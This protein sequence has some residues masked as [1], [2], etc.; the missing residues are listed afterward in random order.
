LAPSVL[1]GSEW[2]PVGIVVIPVME[3]PLFNTALLIIS[4]LAITW[5]HRGIALG[6]FR[7]SIDGFVITVVLGFLFVTL[8]M[9]EYYEAFFNISDSIYST[10]FYTLT[11]LHGMHVIVGASFIT[12]CLIRLFKGHFL[13][14]HYMGFIFAVW[15]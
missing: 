9:F 11:G 15:Y 7:E 10:T 4:G 3:F 13:S 8:Q 12:I 2:P 5:A 6:S 14:N 1:L